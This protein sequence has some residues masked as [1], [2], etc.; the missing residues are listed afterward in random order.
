MRQLHVVTDIDAEKK[1]GTC[2]V[3]ATRVRLFFRYGKWTCTRR[4]VG[5]TAAKTGRTLLHTL[6][7]V[8]EQARTAVCAECGPVR[9]YE[10]QPGAHRF[11]VG[12]KWTCGRRPAERGVGGTP[13]VHQVSDVNEETKMGVCSICGPIKLVWRPYKNGGG[14]WGCFRTRF[15]ISSYTAYKWDENFKPAVCPFCKVTH[16]WDRGQGKK[17]RERLHELHGNS[18][19][20][21][22]AQPDEPLRVDHNHETG[23]VR[24]LLC[25]NCNVALGLM[26]DSPE[27]LQQALSYLQR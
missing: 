10:S 21:C 13:T 23:A 18:C 8:N 3:C 1:H 14:T 16:R 4:I 17:C 11:R 9:I 6:T 5:R 22:G 27:R 25:R 15:S 2:S 20:I 26:Q 7:D 19:N 12:Q 24:G